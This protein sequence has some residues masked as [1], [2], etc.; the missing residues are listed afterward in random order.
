MNEFSWGWLTSTLD[1]GFS[2]RNIA[3]LLWAGLAVLTLS[4]LILARTRW[5]QAQPLSKC[6]FL[7]LYAHFLLGGYAYTTQVILEPPP[8]ARAERVGADAA[9]ALGAG[10][11]RASGARFAIAGSARDG[12]ACRADAHCRDGRAAHVDYGPNR[13]G[14][15]P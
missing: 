8:L 6:V 11:R 13:G 10:G 5:G 3:L 4:L 2:P 7:S 15:D 9:E 12:G 1:E 14:F